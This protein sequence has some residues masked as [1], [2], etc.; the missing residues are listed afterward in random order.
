MVK[1]TVL[2]L[3]ASSTNDKLK[4]ENVYQKI[5]LVFGR[6]YRIVENIILKGTSW[7][8]LVQSP[9]QSQTNF[10]SVAGCSWPGAVQIKKS[11]RVENLQPLW[12]TCSRA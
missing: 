2:T 9:A 12:T 1:L 7:Q 4:L 5:Q 3:A 6:A 11:A 10:K 8:P